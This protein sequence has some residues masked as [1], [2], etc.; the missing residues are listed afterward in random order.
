MIKSPFDISDNKTLAE[1]E[2]I[3]R[4]TREDFFTN[5]NRNLHFL[6]EKR[7]SHIDQ[8][9]TNCDQIL[10]VGSG[11]GFSKL[12]IKRDFISSDIANNEWIDECFS[13]EKIPFNSGTLDAIFVCDTIL[14]LDNPV[15]FF[16][17]VQ[18]VLKPGGL[19]II[20]EINLSLV[21]KMLIKSLKH[22][23]YNFKKDLYL[24]KNELESGAFS[25]NAA[26]LELILSNTNQF[27]KEFGF[28]KKT[29]TKNEFLIYLLSGGVTAKFPYINLPKYLLTF[30][31][32]IDKVLLYFLPNLFA[33]SRKIVLRKSP[34]A[35]S[36][37]KYSG[38]SENSR[39]I[40][41]I[42]S[43]DNEDDIKKN[44]A[45]INLAVGR[46]K[47]YGDI[48]TYEN[49]IIFKTEHLNEIK[50]VDYINESIV[51]QAGVTIN[52]INNLIN[53]ENYILP[54]TGGFEKISVGGAIANDIH[55]KN[56]LKH[57]SFGSQ[58]NWIKILLTDGNIKIISKD[59]YEDL[60]FATLGGIGLTGIILEASLKII[61]VK[62]IGLKVENIALKNTSIFKSLEKYS[63]ENDFC[64][65]II[66][67]HSK[68][69]SSF[70]KY[71]NFSSKDAQKKVNK[72]PFLKISFLRSF[73]RFSNK[74]S[75]KIIYTFLAILYSHG[76]YKKQIHLS[77]YLYTYDNSINYIQGTQ[78]HYVVNKANSEE[79]FEKISNLIIRSS[80][81]INLIVVKYFKGCDTKYFSFPQN[82]FAVSI[83]FKNT[84]KVKLLTS[85][86]ID[87]VISFKG[88]V[89]LAKDKS[90][91][92]EQFSKIFN[93]S[94]FEEIVK[95]YN[96]TMKFRSDASKRYGLN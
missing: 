61:R 14:H 27:D 5:R 86:I 3:F 84:K 42:V 47:S 37:T 82:G 95:K 59:K 48:C 69:K 96:K 51:C 72:L 92:K 81:T 87:T 11:A 1:V 19:F 16:K 57:K 4:S 17:E 33:L 66:N 46:A 45:L 90:L 83:D 15:K 54:V 13:A 9:L 39:K 29:D 22:C 34:I 41:D 40:H 64:Y 60:F 20:Q 89:Y 79:A 35:L 91:N 55:G 67:F 25:S 32:F 70:I 63:L 10:E 93:K 2:E 50:E 36:Q 12:F 75:H 52:Q 53:E 71:A 21:H 30:I 68:N 26:N 94:E 88:R 7:Y 85:D 28:E 62:G 77:D 6:L 80:S 44:I 56:F 18:R 58:V 74:Q 38:W 73:F 23:A 24:E 31:D 43:F 49:Q 8:I 65:G 76:I 78:V